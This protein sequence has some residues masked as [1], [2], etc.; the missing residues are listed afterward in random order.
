MVPPWVTEELRA[1]LGKES[2]SAIAQEVG[3][4]RQRVHQV[5]SKLGIP[6]AI[7]AP[8]RP[9]PPKRCRDCGELSR[10]HARECPVSARARR[11]EG[12]AFQRLTVKQ[13]EYRLAGLCTI[14]GA[15]REPDRMKCRKHLDANAAKVSKARHNRLAQGLCGRCGR[16]PHQACS[17]VCAS[18]QQALAHMVQ[19]RQKASR[20]GGL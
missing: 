9:H 12:A 3:V 13:A 8:H 7:G 5:R 20:G 10:A 19:E 17:Q 1:R 4:S 16:E 2:D 15:P 18:C 11:R 6:A 14:C